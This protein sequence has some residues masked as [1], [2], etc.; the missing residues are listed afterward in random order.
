MYLILNTKF[1]QY[2]IWEPQL[3]Q[4]G[5][6]FDHT[7]SKYSRWIPVDRAAFVGL[8]AIMSQPTHTTAIL[9]EE[10]SA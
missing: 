5:V 10:E 2:R 8:Y 7:H 1:F 6:E 3:E 4:I 9:E